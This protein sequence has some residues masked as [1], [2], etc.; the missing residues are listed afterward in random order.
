MRFF[1]QAFSLPKLGSAEEEYEDA[2]WPT[3]L[4][5]DQAQTAEFRVAV[6]DGATE[7]SFS[8]LWAK[9]IV[10]AYVK[11]R[12]VPDRFEPSLLKLQ[13]RWHKAVGRKPLSWYAEEKV[14]S[15][16]AAAFVGLHLW[17]DA[18]E[19]YG[20]RWEATALG[21]CCLIQMRAEQVIERF[22]I[23]CST[24]F[25]SRPFLLSSQ[26]SASAGW[27]EALKNSSGSWMADD[28]F[29]LISDALAAWFMG[30]EERGGTPWK[31]LRDLGAADSPSFADWVDGLRSKHSMRND[32]VTLVRI[33]LA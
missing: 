2:F 1:A 24:D 14:R 7:T 30:D 20:G 26:P 12:L 9:L 16:A 31:P 15:G 10:R 29:Y 5:A 4:P 13:E 19:E 27:R 17:D 21:D 32:D 18:R 28:R 11:G 22:P 33:D 23:Q 3:Q 8:A 6:A 25:S